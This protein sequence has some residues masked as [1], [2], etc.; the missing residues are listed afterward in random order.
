MRKRKYLV[1]FLLTLIL[2]VIIGYNYMY[3]EHRN[4]SSEKADFI[5][6]SQDLV[7]EYQIDLDEATAKY[8]DK[9]IE[10][11]GKVTDVESDN[12]TLN[13]VIICYSDSLTI[14]SLNITDN[15]KAKGRSI[16]YDELLEH[17]KLDQVTII[18][19]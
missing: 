8:L 18:N 12:F 19:H 13:N 15:I 17:I 7:N 16:G 10:L 9:T 14:Q 6:N 1:V 3:K 11:S 5:L 2:S 4:I